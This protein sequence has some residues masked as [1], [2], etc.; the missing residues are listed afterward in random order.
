MA[1]RLR[2]F[3]P[4]SQHWLGSRPEFRIQVTAGSTLQRYW[5]PFFVK[6]NL[7]RYLFDNDFHYWSFRCYD[8]HRGGGETFQQTGRG[9]VRLVSGGSIDTRP[10]L[11]LEKSCEGELSL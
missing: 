2:Y 10:L 5:R 11:A 4:G 7:L 8:R 9:F 3:L 6:L 1:S